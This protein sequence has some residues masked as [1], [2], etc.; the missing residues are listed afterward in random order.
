MGKRIRKTVV[1]GIVLALVAMVFAGVPMNVSAEGTEDP[2][3]PPEEPIDPGII[4]DRSWCVDG[5]GTYFEI[6]NIDYLN[7]ALTSSENVYVYLESV[8]RMVSYHI[9]A[10]STATSTLITMSGFEMSKTYYRYQ[11]GYLQEE[12][13]TDGSGS[14]SYT[15]DLTN[16]HH[17]FI[18]EETSTLFISS[19]YTFTKD[20]YDNIV[21][22]ADNIVIDG[23][24]FTLYGSGSGNGIYLNSRSGVTIKNLKITGFSYGILIRYGN[25]NTIDN[26]NIFNNNVYGIYMYYYNNNLDNNNMITQNTIS[27]NN[28]AGIYMYLR[29]NIGHYTTISQNK[30]S[31]NNYGINILYGPNNYIISDNTISNNNYGIHIYGGYLTTISS[32]KISDNIEF[33]IGF[34]GWSY[35]NTI[36]FN[37]ISNSYYG[38]YMHEH[39]YSNTISYNT[40][41]NNNYGIYIWDRY[42]WYPYGII[43]HNT[44]TNNDYGI[45]VEQGRGLP[46]HYNTISYNNYGI[47]VE[48]CSG[49]IHYNTI[50]NNNYG[51]YIEQGKWLTIHH[52]NFINNLIQADDWYPETTNWHHPGLLEGNYWS[53]YTGVDD[54]SG[55]GKHAI[56]GD[57]I[58]DTLIPHP[59][60]NYDFYPFT[61]GIG[62]LPPVIDTISGPDGPVAVGK[63]FTITGDF[64]DPNVDDTHTATWTWGEGEPSDGDVNQLEDTVSGEHAYTT[65]GVYQITLTVVDS[66]GL[67]DTMTWSQYIVIYDP[68][69]A[70]I[71]GGGMIDSPE[72]AYT[73]DST[74]TGKAGFGFVSKY[75]KGATTPGGN[76]QFRFHAGDLS[77]KSTEYD[78]L[79]VA[80]AKGQFKG[81]GT[82]NGEGDF[83]FML[84]AIDS[85]L[86]GGG[87][88]DKFRIKIWDKS[89]DITIYDNN[90]GN[91]DYGDPTTALTH[92][93]I[94]IHK[95]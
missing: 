71:T 43:S 77:F 23:D 29:G 42:I 19:D 22:T 35:T 79:V 90:L 57:W 21:V 61:T 56:A 64:T 82:I 27:N 87:D 85:D 92:G 84:T 46:I 47:Y 12:F 81:S 66:F 62:N 17:V 88:T 14:Y 30:I 13:T 70:F 49:Y 31:N 37:T 89:N 5:T 93:S 40:I 2:S 68:S 60:T 80:G 33:G 32:N 50:S 52:N 94:K 59:T 63:Q 83:G 78:W 53:D 18:Q 91:D 67:S 38:I 86:P 65:P 45:Y 58:G 15:Q 74:L 16:P 36:S 9:E 1:F 55:T 28:D 76:T 3:V 6:T 4:D 69:G 72:G 54:G 41:F 26:N 73:A 11:D 51:I 25:H 8:P 24:G 34:T 7:V 95:G 39:C 10:D 75:Q 44:I 48:Y 20:I